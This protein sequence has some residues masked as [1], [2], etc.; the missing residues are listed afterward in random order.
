MRLT[1]ARDVCAQ[2][3]YAG[4]SIKDAAHDVIH[5]R[6]QSAGGDGGVIVLAP[7]GDYVMDFNSAGMFRGV[8]QE[9]GE[10]KVAIYGE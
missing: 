8:K 10:A 9:G 5:N 7:N 6:L 1:I 4:K 2:V 3:E